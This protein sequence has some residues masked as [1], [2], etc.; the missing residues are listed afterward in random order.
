MPHYRFK[1]YTR[2]GNYY[3]EPFV[4][5]AKG[6][7]SRKDP[8]P[9]KTTQDS[10]KTDRS[11]RAKK[12]EIGIHEEL[13]FIPGFS[14]KDPIYLDWVSRC[15]EEACKDSRLWDDLEEFGDWSPNRKRKRPAYCSSDPSAATPT[16]P[17]PKASKRSRPRHPGPLPV[18]SYRLDFGKHRY[19]TLDEVPSGYINW[20]IS[21]EVHSGRPDLAA[22]LK[23]DGLLTATSD[24]DLDVDSALRT[25]RIPNRIEK[26]NDSFYDKFTDDARWIALGDAIKYFQVDANLLRVA[27]IQSLADKTP[28]YPLYQVYFCA[29]HFKTTANGTTQQAL[30]AFQRKNERREKEIMSEMFDFY[31]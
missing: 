18:Q 1:E 4:E 20:L 5:A 10:P 3:E 8:A 30:D 26:Y 27:G 6:T 12:P 9:G 24:P 31:D 14:H 19:K 28:R 16:S 7:P 17:T 2:E 13:D 21:N 22:A 15:A 11:P 25:W 29:D 23:S